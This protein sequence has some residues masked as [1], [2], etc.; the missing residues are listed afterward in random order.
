MDRPSIAIPGSVRV[1]LIAN[2][3]LR[4]AGGASGVLVG[5]SLAESANRGASWGA[6][7]AGTLGAVVTRDSTSGQLLA[8]LLADQPQALGW[9]LLGYEQQ[10]HDRRHCAAR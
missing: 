4:I 3:L 9:V 2:G 1:A 8:G 7:L 6:A 5:L 10:H